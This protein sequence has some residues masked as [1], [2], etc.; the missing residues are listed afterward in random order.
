[1]DSIRTENQELQNKIR[2]YEE[3]LESLDTRIT[4][5]KS[6]IKCL[7]K[8][9]EKRDKTIKELTEKI[10]RDT[11]EKESY[12]EEVKKLKAEIVRLTKSKELKVCD[13]QPIK[14]YIDTLTSKIDTLE[15]SINQKNIEYNT[16]DIGKLNKQ[17][18][19]QYELV[20]R[21]RDELAE[22]K[23]TFNEQCNTIEKLENKLNHSTNTIEEQSEQLQA[24]YIQVDELKA[25]E[26]ELSMREDDISELKDTLAEKESEI[27]SLKSKWTATTLSLIIII[28]FLGLCL[29]TLNYF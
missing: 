7:N 13:V 1:M 5:H 21:L 20:D 28:V 19:A 25:V 14:N 22:S 23:L 26:M 12:T 18:T 10:N 17:L 8:D 3:K 6:T 4:N 24:Y 2:Q 15:E 29:F 9:I 11:F 27:E 16:S